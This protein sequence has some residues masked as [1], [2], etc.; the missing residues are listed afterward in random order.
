MVGK[1]IDEHLRT[2]CLIF[3]HLSKA[4]LKINLKKCYFL[5]K[6]IE[7]LGHVIDKNGV[8]ATKKKLEAI[9]KAAE[10]TNSKEGR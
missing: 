10:P 4:G 5:K 2:L 8:R 9:S 1:D 6:E 3:E 7:Y